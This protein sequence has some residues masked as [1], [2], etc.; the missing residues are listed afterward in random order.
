MERATVSSSLASLTNSV[1]DAIGEPWLFL[2]DDFP[3]KQEIPVSAEFSLPK[4]KPAPVGTHRSGFDCVDSVR[5]WLRG[6]GWE[7]A[8]SRLQILDQAR[9]MLS[10]FRFPLRTITKIVRK[11]TAASIANPTTAAPTTTSQVIAMTF[12]LREHEELTSCIR[13]QARDIAKRPEN[14]R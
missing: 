13:L 2:G 11:I 1:L 4:A 9:Y 12:P 3:K 10:E 8:E 7:S 14:S 6:A 5:W